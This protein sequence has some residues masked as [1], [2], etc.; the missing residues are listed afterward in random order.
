M[1]RCSRWLWT[2]AT[3]GGSE[4][5]PPLP[6]TGCFI[7]HLEAAGARFTPETLTGVS[8]SRRSGKG[9]G[10]WRTKA[11]WSFGNLFLFLSKFFWSL[12]WGSR[13]DGKGGRQAACWWPALCML[14]A[15]HR[16][17]LLQPSQAP[18]KIRT[19]TI[20]FTMR[21]T[22]LKIREKW[23]GVSRVTQPLNGQN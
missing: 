16:S 17:H 22:D 12:H 8:I 15:G 9:Q 7:L 18:C 20:R 11:F 1:L 2:P 14:R 3:G 4:R 13:M 5:S 19:V 6:F 10:G 21:K 23:G